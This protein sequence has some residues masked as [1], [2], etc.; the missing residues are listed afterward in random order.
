M[1]R[2]LPVPVL[3]CYKS[4]S[5]VLLLPE[6]ISLHKLLSF[7]VPKINYD[8]TQPLNRC[9]SPPGALNQSANT[10]QVS[11]FSQSYKT[12]EPTGV[13]KKKINLS[14]RVIPE[15]AHPCLDSAGS[16]RRQG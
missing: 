16:Y 7:H 4:T 6:I 5:M 15:I 10:K 2:P 9:Y 11:Y 14:D 1:Y 8:Y 13:Q 12:N 3:E